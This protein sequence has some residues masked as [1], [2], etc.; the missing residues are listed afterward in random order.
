MTKSGLYLIAGIKYYPSYTGDTNEEYIKLLVP[1]NDAID[2]E[3]NLHTYFP[4]RLNLIKRVTRLYN[5]RFDENNI[6]DLAIV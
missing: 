2:A 6:I 3:H 1:G 4:G 5:G